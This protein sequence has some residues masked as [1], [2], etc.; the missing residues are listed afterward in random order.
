MMQWIGHLFDLL[1]VCNLNNDNYYVGMLV[2]LAEISAT[3][4]VTMPCGCVLVGLCVW[5]IAC[6]QEVALRN[7][8]S[9]LAS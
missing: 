6:G 4:H 7:L 8:Y 1:L 5:F 2:A 3:S 9:E